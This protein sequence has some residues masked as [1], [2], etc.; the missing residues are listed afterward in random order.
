MQTS[1]TVTKCPITHQSSSYPS[2]PQRGKNTEK[3]KTQTQ[4]RSQG[5]SSSISWSGPG[6]PEGKSKRLFHFHFNIT[7]SPISAPAL[8]NLTFE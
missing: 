2:T 3:K 8:V 6:F 5:L 4:P 1:I 7:M